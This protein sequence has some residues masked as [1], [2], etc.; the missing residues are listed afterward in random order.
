MYKLKRLALASLV[1]AATLVPTQSQAFFGWMMPWNWFGNGWGW[2]D[3]YYPYYG[4][5]YPYYGGYPY[6]GHPWGA[7]PYGHH[8]GYYGAHPYWGGTYYPYAYGYTYT[9]PATLQAQADK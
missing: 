5:Y 9:V 8:W 7:Y 4:G 2:H 3:Y 1:A 6:R